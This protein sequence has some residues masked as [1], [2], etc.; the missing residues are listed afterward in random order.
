MTRVLSR[1]VLPLF[2]V[3][4]A[5][6]LVAIGCSQARS[7][8]P[9]V[10][11]ERD[12][13]WQQNRERQATLDR[14]D[15]ELESQRGAAGGVW[16][17]R[18]EAAPLT[19]RSP[20]DSPDFSLQ[21]SSGGGAGGGG[22]GLFGNG[23][24]AA[25]SQPQGFVA[26]SNQQPRD[27]GQGLVGREALPSAE[28]ELWV[29][30]KPDAPADAAA[31]AGEGDATP[32]S[33]VLVTTLPGAEKPVPVPL[34]HTAVKAGI[35]GYI[36]TVDVKQQFHNP[37]DGK[38]EAVYVF[39]LPSNAAVN[40]F[41]M[42]VGERKIRGVIRERQEAKRIYTEARASGHVA[43]L[44]TQERPNVFTQSVANIEPGKAIDIDIRYFH[45]LG[46]ND[47]WY[48][49]VFPMVVGPRFNPPG[50]TDGVGSVGNGNVGAS[51]QRTE[52]QYLRPQERSG[53][54]VSLVVELNAGVEIEKIE[55]PNHKVNVERGGENR[56][57]VALAKDDSLPNRDF[58]LRYKVAGDRTKSGLI[59]QRDEKG[60]GYFTLM[61]VPP[62][63]LGSL[64]PR[65]LEMV[66]TLDVSGSM[67]GAPIAQSKNAMRYAL[68]H[69]NADD[70]FQIVQFAGH[71][72][73][74]A[75]RPL[76]ATREN[77]AAAM[78]Y[79]ERTQAGGGTMMLEGI[80]ASL[81]FPHDERRL[82][83]VSF[84]TDGYI[85]N[86][87]EI[88]KA[89][90]PALGP[91]RVFSFGVG[92]A[93]NRYLL[94]ALA[95]HG[96]GAVAY[97]G[98]NDDANAVMAHFYDRIRRPALT[99]VEIDWGGMRVSEVFP[100]QTP[101]LFVGRPVVLTGKFTGE[102]TETVKVRGRVGNEIQTVELPVKLDAPPAAAAAE[103]KALPAVWA[104]MKIADLADEAAMAPT[105]DIAGEVRQVALEYGLMSSFTSFVAVDS[106][107][108][109]EGAF[110]TTVAVPVPVP[111]GVRYETAVQDGPGK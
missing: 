45:T 22:G 30:A 72:T 91:A 4:V 27:R 74:M 111:Q 36:A 103:R 60:Q 94:D 71:A 79:L 108:R 62:E 110:G 18:P 25:A 100:R 46:Y 49:F 11:S 24:G 75:E 76:P 9:Y 83:F 86:E 35:A 106:S 15:A 26:R 90:K 55:S 78:A 58:V 39:P 48:E 5:A 28:E 105:A 56:A 61:L 70:T 80:R 107:A 51:G 13:L 43:S 8:D 89:V 67:N 44:L 98:L 104:R 54:D 7:V 47:G 21:Q 95:K 2:L 65:P 1:I 19:V 23:G 93:P 38:I 97:L 63:N 92:Q 33:G 59:V 6:A 50:T 64:P 99:D 52:V 42:T 96:R 20:N 88:L 66:F 37:Y 29:I 40:E 82:R 102:G 81:D 73:R 31:D 16:A 53:H 34:K 10:S 101:D 3:L 12:A 17:P 85:G 32:G 87:A 77:V 41:V 14:K 84:L 109:T 69:M 57:T 68:T